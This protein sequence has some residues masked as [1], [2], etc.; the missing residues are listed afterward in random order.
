M[1]FIDRRISVDRAIAML[2]KNGIDVDDV[3]AAVILDFL[4]LIS[5][6]RNKPEEAKNAETL[7][8][9]RILEKCRKT[10]VK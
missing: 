6:N 4:Y 10:T 1:N 8:R 9:N 5:K 7:K 3:E 2:A